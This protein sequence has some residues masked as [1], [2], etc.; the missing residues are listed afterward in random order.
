VP[1][2]RHAAGHD[3]SQVI[4]HATLRVAAKMDLPATVSGDIRRS[5]GVR[6]AGTLASGRRVQAGAET[7]DIHPISQADPLLPGHRPSAKPRC[8]DVYGPA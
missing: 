3:D 7:R 6:G 1:A 2:S 4:R 5:R 8:W